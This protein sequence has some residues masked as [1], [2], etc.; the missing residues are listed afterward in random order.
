MTDVG[1]EIYQ[2]DDENMAKMK[3]KAPQVWELFIAD[4]NDRGYPGDEIVKE[5]VN[6][7]KT[8]GEKPAYDPY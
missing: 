6:F 3:A 2:F 8:V 4:L 7:L 1:I 5:Y